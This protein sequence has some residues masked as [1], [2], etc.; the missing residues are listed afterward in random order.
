MRKKISLSTAVTLLLLTAALTISITMLLAMRYFNNQVQSVSQRQAMYTHIN[1]VDKTVRDYYAELDE[2]LLRQGITEGYVEGLGDDYAAYFTPNEYVKEQL[3][4]SGKANNVGVEVCY[5]AD[6]HI[7][8]CTVHGDSAAA[9]AGVEVGDV[10]TALDSQPVEGTSLAAVQNYLNTTEKVLISV[11]REDTTTAFDLSAFQYTVRS[12]ETSIINNVGY[13][14]LTDFYQNT[15]NQF[16]SKLEALLAEGVSGVVFD[17]RDNA[18]GLQSAAQEVI[19]Y[20]MPLGMYGSVTDAHGAVTNLS[21]N[22]SNQIGVSTVTLVNGNTAGEAEFF[23]GVLQEFGLTT[24]VGETTA[25]KAKIQDYFTLEV[26]NSAIKL[27]VGEYSLL[28]GGSWQGKGI[29]PTM[30]LVLPKTQASIYRLL[31]PEEDVQVQAAVVQI[32]NSDATVLNTTT[33]ETTAPPSKVKENTTTT[34]K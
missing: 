7:A 21:S 25:G 27:T 12:V 33:T 3:R 11:Q 17:L 15:P 2:E 28:K 14:R 19:S 1:T 29:I 30:E 4:L 8:V 6:K 16:R 34:K 10:I 13:L 20:L 9:K 22:V 24:V 32:A 26:D 5:N 31:T 23:A 18:G